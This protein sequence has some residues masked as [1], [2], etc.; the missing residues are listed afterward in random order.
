MTKLNFI[1]S[2]NEKLSGLPQND[3]EERLRFYTEM[4]E[5]RMEE[6]LSEEEAVLAVGS[7]DEIAEQILAEASSAPSGKSV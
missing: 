3:I 4:I 5:D 2:L 7:V 1:L 6:G